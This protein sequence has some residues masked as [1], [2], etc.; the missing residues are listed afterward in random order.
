MKSLVTNWTASKIRKSVYGAGVATR[1]NDE[2]EIVKFVIEKNTRTYDAGPKTNWDLHIVIGGVSKWIDSEITL[3]EMKNW[4]SCLADM[5]FSREHG[6]IKV[7]EG[8]WNNMTRPECA[9]RK[10]RRAAK[11]ANRNS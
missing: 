11:L 10:A 6:N 4:A 2:L 9:D 1:I 7:D 3:K 5:G 8:F